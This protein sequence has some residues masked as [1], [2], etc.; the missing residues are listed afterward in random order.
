MIKELLLSSRMSGDGHRKEIFGQIPKTIMPLQPDDLPHTAHVMPAIAIVL[1][2]PP[3]EHDL[4][5]CIPKT[6][7]HPDDPKHA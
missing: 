2:V 7:R 3:V 6:R 4:C 5:I 1:H